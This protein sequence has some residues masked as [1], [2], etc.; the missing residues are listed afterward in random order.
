MKK[1][2]FVSG[3]H[4]AGKGTLCRLLY[5]QLDV[6][7]YAASDL[8]KSHSQYVEENKLIDSADKNQQ[9]L[10]QGLSRL[11]EDKLLLDG[12]FCLLNKN[13]EIVKL[14]YSVFDAMKLSLVV[15]VECK[16]VELRGRL[17]TRDGTDFSVEFLRSFQNAEYE[18]AQNFCFDRNI[19]LIK[20]QSGIDEISNI[21]N[22]IEKL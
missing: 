15:Y 10:I 17:M 11:Q 6:K 5:E 9:A 20:Y 21:A 12:H 4:G 19:P 14:N 1:I 16:P 22:V 8:I 13:K 3:V 2:V 18:H 7:S